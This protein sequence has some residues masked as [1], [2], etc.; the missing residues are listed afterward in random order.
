MLKLD[1]PSLRPCVATYV[2]IT[3]LDGINLRSR[4]KQDQAFLYELRLTLHQNMQVYSVVIKIDIFVDSEWN[5]RTQPYV[6]YF[7]IKLLLI[8]PIYPNDML[9]KLLLNVHQKTLRLAAG[10]ERLFFELATYYENF[11]DAGKRIIHVP[12]SNNHTS[13]TLGWFSSIEF[14]KNNVKY[15][16]NFP[17]SSMHKTHVCPYVQLKSD[18]FVMDFSD[19]FLVLKS[20]DMTS[21]FSPFE[22]QLQNDSVFICLSDFLPFYHSLSTPETASVNRAGMLTRMIYL[23]VCIKMSCL[24]HLII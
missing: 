7:I 3:A 19:E 16:N 9:E 20:D 11:N 15:C 18:E 22:Y 17:L 10:Q 21:K 12:L 4:L 8:D 24:I 14:S 13:T 23:T 6:D 2:K 5:D 1:L